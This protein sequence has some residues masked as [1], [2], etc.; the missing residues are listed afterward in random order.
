MKKLIITF[1]L[2]MFICG[3]VGGCSNADSS[4]SE[5]NEDTESVIEMS[6]EIAPPEVVT[7]WNNEVEIGDYEWTNGM[8]NLEGND[9]SVFDLTFDK[10]V[11][12][13]FT[14]E[15][16]S[17]VFENEMLGMYFR[18]TTQ[19]LYIIFLG[20]V[21]DNITD[22]VVNNIS[23]VDSDVSFI[24]GLE[25]GMSQDEV[26]ESMGAPVTK[27]VFDKSITSETRAISDGSLSVNAIYSDDETLAGMSLY[28][29]TTVNLSSGDEPV[30]DLVEES[31][32]G[33]VNYYEG[34]AD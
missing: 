26:N 20:N 18:G 6:T 16:D 14:P 28:I 17:A 5:N 1:L 24:P 19:N 15:T 8:I 4:V 23:L 27:S 32:E 3:L 10:L 11:E 7:D 33:F 29:S 25:I 12:L 21:G 31:T 13:G 30:E 22:G 9:V 2:T 34:L